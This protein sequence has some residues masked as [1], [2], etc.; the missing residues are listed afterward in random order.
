MVGATQKQAAKAVGVTE[1]T[2]RRW[3]ADEKWPDACAG[4]RGRWLQGVEV[5]ARA[6]LAEELKNK[7]NRGRGELALKVLERLDPV[8]APARQRLEM[9]WRFQLIER[10]YA[11][12]VEE[13]ERLG[14]EGT[15][16]EFMALLSGD[17][18]S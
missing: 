18:I 9:D 17:G 3:E 14:V 11:L 8:F 1:R 4:A 5:E 13:L 2:L 10:A 7:T 15:E 12:P 6:A 16:E